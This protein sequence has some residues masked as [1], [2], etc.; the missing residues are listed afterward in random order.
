MW[1]V[2]CLPCIFAF[3][4]WDFPWALGLSSQQ[5]LQEWPQ[6]QS[7]SKMEGGG[8]CCSG[9]PL[10]I[11]VTVPEPG[12]PP[13]CSWLRGSH[14]TVHGSEVPTFRREIMFRATWSCRKHLQKLRLSLLA[15]ALWQL[16]LRTLWS[17]SLFCSHATA[18]LSHKWC[19]WEHVVFFSPKKDNCQVMVPSWREQHPGLKP[20]SSTS[21]PKVSTEKL[22]VVP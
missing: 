21:P 11:S 7:S 5:Y 22:A 9:H 3:F 17:I 18:L 8:L 12:G 2:S 14:L 16:I 20:L 4:Q 19:N 13:R 6:T 10:R 1:L 15:Q